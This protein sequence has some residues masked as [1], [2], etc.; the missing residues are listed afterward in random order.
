ML[1]NIERLRE[2]SRWLDGIY[3]TENVGGVDALLLDGGSD[4]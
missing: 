4:D 3:A 2:F 1:G